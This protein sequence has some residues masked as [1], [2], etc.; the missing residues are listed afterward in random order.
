[1][2]FGNNI[3]FLC[4][5]WI[6]RDAKECLHLVVFPPTAL[7]PAAGEAATL[8]AGVVAAFLANILLMGSVEIFAKL[9]VSQ[10]LNPNLNG[11][12]AFVIAYAVATLDL[13]VSIPSSQLLR[14]RSSDSLNQQPHTILAPRP[15]LR[16]PL[17]VLLILET[18]SIS[19]SDPSLTPEI[20]SKL[21][22][23]LFDPV[24]F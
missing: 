1:M 22:N 18:L 19:I 24:T 12:N 11:S 5:R 20:S 6:D 10:R 15:P 23:T 16:N 9:G 8:V 17:S 2:K 4:G 3:W 7:V 21:L 14:N 13:F